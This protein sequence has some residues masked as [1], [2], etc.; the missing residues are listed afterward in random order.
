M[1]KLPV[2]VEVED[3]RHPSESA[4][5]DES[6]LDPSLY[7][8]FVQARPERI[9][10]AKLNGFKTVKPEETGE[11]TL[12]EQDDDTPEGVLKHGDRILMAM[13]KA[14]ATERAKKNTALADMRLRSH[15]QRVREMAKS[16]KIKLHEA[17]E[18][19]D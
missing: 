6:T 8:R 12:F 14:K 13:P 7:Y 16:R 5:L 9:S 2:N 10:R 19:D 15:D 4:V 3:R 17:D 11:R 1:A 18:E